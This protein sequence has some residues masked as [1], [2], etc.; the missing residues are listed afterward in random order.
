ML[1]EKFLEEFRSSL[2]VKTASIEAEALKAL[3]VYDWPGN[4]RELRNVIERSLVLHGDQ[5]VLTLDLLPNEFHRN[6][7][8]R[9]KHTIEFEENLSKSVDQI[10]RELVIE[11]LRICGSVQTKAA[12]K[13]GTTRRILKYKMDKLNIT[14][15]LD[16][17]E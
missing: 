17:P 11:A 3:C 10:E 7:H 16:D 14:L 12:E 5:E 4:I 8:F 1:A 6:K 9:P 15:P 2:H 13:L